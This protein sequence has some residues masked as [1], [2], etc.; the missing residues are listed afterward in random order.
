MLKSRRVKSPACR[1]LSS[2]IF[3]ILIFFRPTACAKP[4]LSEHGT[5]RELNP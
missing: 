3:S 1:F 2:L 5:T 4:L